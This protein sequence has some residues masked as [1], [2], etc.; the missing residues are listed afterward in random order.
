MRILLQIIQFPPDV[1]ST[2][3][4]MMQVCEGLKHL[5][6]EIEVITSFPH[7]EKFRTWQEYRGK[8][9]QRETVSGMKVLRL[10]V[11]ARGSK[12]MAARLLSY[13]TFNLLAAGA[14][15]LSRTRVD[16]VLC[17][18]GSFF[19]G[20]SAYVGGAFQRVPFVY[21]V[22]DLYPEVAVRTGQLH[23]R[24][25]IAILERIASFMY[26][27]AAHVTVI[28]PA[29]RRYLA[30]RGV[31]EE[32]IS[33]I[34]NFVDTEFIRPLPR[35][36]EFSRTHDLDGKFVVTHAGNV[37]HVYDLETMLEVA[38]LVSSEEGIVFLMVGE[39]VAKAELVATARQMQLSNVRFLPF[40]PLE[41]LPWLRA[42]SDV[43]VSLYKHGS[44]DYSMP[45][46]V[47]EIMASGRPLLASAD[48]GT[49][50]W[51]LVETTRCGI[52]VAPEDP[53]QLS[54]ALLSLYRDRS[55]SEEMGER[56]RRFAEQEYSREAVVAAYNRLLRD[57]AIRHAP[58]LAIGSQAKR[59]NKH[60]LGR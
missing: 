42:S 12:T 53:Q 43:Q 51:A 38:G 18:N 35:I 56:G 17:T 36:N 1:N 39:G 21:N 6:N 3:L 59:G 44:G 15:L 31:P 34:P 27:K 4:L 33:V 9:A 58:R 25:A 30:A 19:T 57:I 49:D 54:E 46:K 23:N 5:G 22:Q 2:G 16:V 24:F 13:L 50:L 45:S 41:S 14:R 8:L 60:V 40:Q 28:T 29:F 52:C 55:L 10:Y 7:Y 48:P 11:Y 47:Y 20:V 32:K 37:G 26:R